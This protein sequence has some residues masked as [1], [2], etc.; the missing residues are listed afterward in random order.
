VRHPQ[1]GRKWYDVK[2]YSNRFKEHLSKGLKPVY[3][4]TGEEPLQVNECSDALREKAR[5]EGYTERLVYSVDIDTSS[6]EFLQA[7]D[8]LSLFAE[9]KLLEVRLPRGKTG[10]E[11]AQAL[12]R[13]LDAPP[14]DMVLLVCGGKLER[15]VSNSAWYKKADKLGAT[16]TTWPKNPQ[17]LL[18]WIEQRLQQHGLRATRSAKAL[19][20]QRV[21]GNLLAA[22]QEIDKLALLYP[23]AQIGDAE[24]MSAVAN[25]SRYSVFDLTQAA[26]E[27]NARR[28]CKI[29]QVLEGEGVAEILVH[30]SLAQEVRQLSQIAQQQLAGVPAETALRQARVPRHR[31]ALVRKALNRHTERQ[32]LTLLRQAARI[33]RLIKGRESGDAWVELLQLALGIA[34]TQLAI[35]DVDTSK[36]G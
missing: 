15:G 23:D 14:D 36:V 28:A 12:N 11:W 30:W 33:D 6:D 4:I 27:G 17:E 18:A 10:R 1:V 7:S 21:E 31:V 16:V 20:A 25:S 5:A 22:R 32:W 35:P 19:I 2:L 34:G 13:Y 3:V 29:L 8:N 9:K 24:V 26:L